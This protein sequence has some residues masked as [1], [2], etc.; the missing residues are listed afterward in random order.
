[1]P[2]DEVKGRSG[3]KH[4]SERTGV[5][6]SGIVSRKDGRD[7]ALFF[8]GKQHAGENL[9]DVLRRREAALD[10]PI[11][12]CDALS[13]NLPQELKVILC[14]CTAHSRRRFVEV[15]ESFPE[16]CRYVIETLAAVY[17][18][19]AVAKERGMSPEERLRFHQ[20]SSGPLMADLDRWLVDQIEGL[21][22]EPNC[23]LG[24]AIE[25]AIDHWEKLTRFLHVPGAPLDNS[26]VERALK[27]SILRRKNSLFYRTQNGARVGDIFTS[28][29]YTCQL[30]GVDPF[31]YLTEI[32][33]HAAELAANPRDWMPWNYRATLARLRDGTSPA[34]ATTEQ[35]PPAA[36]LLPRSIRSAPQGPGRS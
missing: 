15:V 23:G 12:M 36:A 35:F 29:I 20:D 9:A 4:P 24:E 26:V 25:Y 5:F 28:L 21:K 27:K 19:D 18:N 1:M 13:R 16:E 17:H 31:H 3:A 22:V 6:T 2:A 7:I 10:A 32:Q 34:G 8:T 14:N 30:S 33:K 11:Q